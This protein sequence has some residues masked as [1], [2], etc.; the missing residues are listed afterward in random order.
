MRQPREV[1]KAIV[2]WTDQRPTDSTPVA[3]PRRTT[4]LDKAID[5]LY[6]G[7]VRQEELIDI[8]CQ[9]FHYEQTN[10]KS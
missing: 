1:P 2:E 4:D 5:Q 7:R 9:C 3:R 10:Q 8:I 6:R